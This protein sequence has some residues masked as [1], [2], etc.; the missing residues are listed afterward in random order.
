MKRTIDLNFM[1]PVNYPKGDKYGDRSGTHYG[2]D[3]LAPRGTAVKAS[4]DGEV[5][6]GAFNS[7]YGH[8]VIINHTPMAKEN[9]RHIYTLYAHLSGTNVSGGQ[10]VKKEETIG[11]V[12][13]TGKTYSTTGGDGSH[14][15][16]EVIDTGEKGGKMNWGTLGPTNY[17][18]HV[19]RVNPMNY[20]GRVT[21]IEY[22]L[23]E[24]EMRKI[25]GS[26][27]I[28]PVIDFKRGIYRFDLYLGKKKVG[29]FD[30][31]HK[32][33]SVKLSPEELDGILRNPFPPGR[34]SKKIVEIKI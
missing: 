11:Y 4:E 3:Y 25:E 20:F 9:Q 17:E 18:K 32:E 7:T 14:L 1:E 16:F 31:S 29:Y 34:D 27:D 6:R 8:L 10:E 28:D 23:S 5:V 21:T 15:H 2:I 13:N 30:K 22:H 24:E 12:S 33:V 26:L 19:N